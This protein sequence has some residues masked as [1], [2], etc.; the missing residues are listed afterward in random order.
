M[1]HPELLTAEPNMDTITD[2]NQSAN[3][4]NEN[5]NNA[6]TSVQANRE[7]TTTD[8]CHVKVY[9]KKDYDPK[10]RQEVARLLLTAFEKEGNADEE[11]TS[12]LS[13]QSINEKTA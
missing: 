1:K 13:V 3:L 2:G 11:E 7:F 5:K 12:S 4:D 6:L 8:G 10:I 9:F